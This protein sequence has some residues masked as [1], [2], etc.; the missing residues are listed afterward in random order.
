MRSQLLSVFIAFSLAL[1]ALG[2]PRAEAEEPFDIVAN[3]IEALRTGDTIILKSC[4]G[5]RLLEKRELLLDQNQEY[6]EFLRNF[7][8]GAEFQISD[9]LSDLGPR[10][11]GIAIEIRFPDGNRIESMAIVE[12]APDGSWLIVDEAEARP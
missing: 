4:I 2:A 11:Q 7:Y 1:V 9:E 3:Y 8:E 5:G 10:G 6:P 12:E